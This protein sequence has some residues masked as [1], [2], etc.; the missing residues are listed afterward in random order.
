MIPF[1]R[2]IKELIIMTYSK[3]DLVQ[4]KLEFK[5]TE[6]VGQQRSFFNS[7]SEEKIEL[8]EIQKRDSQK[9]FRS[10]KAI[11]RFFDDLDYNNQNISS[12]DLT[13]IRK[14]EQKDYHDAA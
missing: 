12:Y 14:Q 5:I 1:I 9:W 10:K 2:R 8:P 13:L 6:E 3:S 4:S 7:I 11:K